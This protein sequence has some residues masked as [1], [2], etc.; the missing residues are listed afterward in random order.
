MLSVPAH[1]CF[2]KEQGM[3]WIII[4]IIVLIGLFDYALLIACSHLEDEEQYKYEE[5]LR[6]KDDESDNN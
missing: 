4:G 5:W 6:S 2:R 3:K 1:P